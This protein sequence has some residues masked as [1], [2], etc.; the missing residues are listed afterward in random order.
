MSDEI[1]ILVVDDNKILAETV[2]DLL[3]L[4]E[5]RLTVVHS[6][7]EALESVRKF[8]LPHLAI[9]DLHLGRHK[10]TG[11]ELCAELHSFSSI[12]IIMLTGEDSE[13]MMVEGLTQYA[14][15]YITKPFQVKELLAR[16]WRV[17]QRVGDFAYTLDPIIAVD[18][19]L[20]I[21][22]P[23][24][25]IYLDNE[26]KSLTPTESKLLYILM[27][28]AGR[29]VTANYL[30]RQIWPLEEAYEDRLHPHVYR[31]RKKLETNPRI[32][33]YLLSDW[34]VGYSFINPKE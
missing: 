30:I 4:P 25:K 17:L 13:E 8:G 18:E 28:N 15:D 22:F 2:R 31:L 6:G 23:N 16:V 9:V 34:G 26:E 33:H 1:R 20:Q 10:M 21:D 12:P 5:Y 29:T 3:D 32:P 19:H 11:F 24:R 14:D 27:K 7:E